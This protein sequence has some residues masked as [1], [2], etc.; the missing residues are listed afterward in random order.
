LDRSYS[1]LEK[2]IMM[3]YLGYKLENMIP[4]PAGEATPRTIYAS[5]DGVLL[6]YG[7]TDPGTGA[8]YAPGCLFI[9]INGTVGTTLYVNEGTATTA[10]FDAVTVA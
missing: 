7:T 5:E 10:D 3:G 8:G 6:C 1:Q 4:A 9:K 2:E